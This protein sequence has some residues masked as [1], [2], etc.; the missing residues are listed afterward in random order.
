MQIALTEPQEDFIWQAVSEGRYA[1]ESEVVSTGISLV[2]AR[3][4]KLAELRAMI[5]ESF[6]D[7]R[8]VTKEVIDK[9]LTQ[10][11]AELIAMGIP[12]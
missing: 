8:I 7:T 4:Q 2:R 9:A 3:G 10:Q 12:E 11:K 1:S 5:Q 6:K